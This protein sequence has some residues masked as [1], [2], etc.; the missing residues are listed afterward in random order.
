MLIRIYQKK[1]GLDM[2]ITPNGKKRTGKSPFLVARAKSRASSLLV[3]HKGEE[4]LFVLLTTDGPKLVIDGDNKELYG[5]SLE[6]LKKHN[7]ED[8]FFGLY[9]EAYDAKFTIINNEEEKVDTLK[10]LLGK[11]LEDL[12]LE[13]IREFV[14]GHKNYDRFICPNIKKSIAGNSI[15]DGEVTQDQTYIVDE[16]I[17]LSCIVIQQQLLMPIYADFLA[18]HV[19]GGSLNKPTMLTIANV[20]K[21]LRYL[22]NKDVKRLLR[23]ITAHLERQGGGNIEKMINI[24]TSYKVTD[25]ELPMYALSFLLFRKFPTHPPVC[26]INGKGIKDL[27]TESYGCVRNIMLES[28]IKTPNK[29]NPVDSFNG[30]GKESMYESNHVTTDISQSDEAMILVS[31]DCNNRHELEGL[32]DILYEEYDI[33]PTDDEYTDLHVFR[34]DIEGYTIHE[35]NLWLLTIFSTVLVP[36]RYLNILGPSHIYNLTSVIYMLVD[37]LLGEEIAKMYKIEFRCG[38][39]IINVGSKGIKPNNKDL[40]RLEEY[41]P[42]RYTYKTESKLLIG[43]WVD[44]LIDK[45]VECGKVN[46]L[47]KRPMA[48]NDIKESLLSMLIV[49][50]RDKK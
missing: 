41:Y 1:K 10:Y 23:Y 50:V 42:I 21:E 9:K 27:A 22:D 39:S 40:L 18:C 12:S 19:G 15:K 20:L 36:S 32:L 46:A 6:Y 29:I 7:I 35:N 44:M 28:A 5:Y 47:T 31:L 49:S 16:Y 33:T 26:I 3:E 25:D 37:R 24:A 38:E 34:K 45:L 2:N 8:K 43:V 11:A 13:S 30:E 14:E 17:G 4:L 48:I